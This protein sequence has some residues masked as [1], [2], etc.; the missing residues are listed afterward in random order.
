MKVIIGESQNTSGPLRYYK[1]N[2]CGHEDRWTESHRYIE[3]PVSGQYEV[4]Q[5]EIQFISCS[6]ECRK[7]QREKF[8]NWLSHYPGWNK[9]KSAK[10]Y[11]MT[12]KTFFATDKA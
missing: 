10:N 4:Q 9:I 11:D 2:V 8:I 12:F 6:D 5:Y 3:R 7:V 1:C